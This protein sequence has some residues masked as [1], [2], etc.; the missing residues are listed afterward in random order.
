MARTREGEASSAAPRSSV[1]R[2]C[3]IADRVAALES[4]ID[5]R[6]TLLAKLQQEASHEPATYDDI[7]AAL[8]ALPVIAKDLTEL[9]QT[10]L[11]Q[12]FDSLG[13]VL[14]Y[15]PEPRVVDLQV[16]LW[17]DD[18]GEETLRTK[19]RIGGRGKARPRNSG[20][21]WLA[22]S[23]GFE[24]SHPAPEAS[25]LS[26]ELRGRGAHHTLWRRRPRP[27]P[28][29]PAPLGSRRARLDRA[30]G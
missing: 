16:T 1:G 27:L 7:E 5:E 19:A 14:R 22:P 25:A 17:R 11:R 30:G 9:P 10:Q 8:R 6:R 28:A 24:P 18:P 20:E 26:P 15:D 21:V 3:R 23:E 13:L 29:A 2:A 12:L 4:S